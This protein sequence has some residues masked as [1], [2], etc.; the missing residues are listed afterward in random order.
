[1]IPAGYMAKRVQKPKGF[2]ID[3]IADVCSVSG[4]VNED[5]ADYI[6]YWK[7]NGYWLFDSPEI[8]RK[9]A[10]MHSIQLEGT[11]LFYYEVYE[12]EFDGKTWS[13][14]GAES[15]FPTNV[16]PPQGKV[17]EGFDVVTF[18]AGNAPEHSPLS[19]NGMA[20]EIRTN[21]HCLL[22]SLSEAY[23]RLNGGAFKNADPGPYRIFAV[24]SVEWPQSS[25]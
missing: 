17:L 16:T 8:I 12:T 6:E 5:F 18:F 25:D 13:P 21:Q 24:Y 20:K 1:M 7:H 19:C 11:S 22:E 14:Y 10:K 15:S 2:Q 23:D 3:G 9:I 4:C